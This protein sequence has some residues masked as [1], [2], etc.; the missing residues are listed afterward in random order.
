MLVQVPCFCT[1]HIASLLDPGF[2]V[3]PNNNFKIKVAWKSSP[4]IRWP[5]FRRGGRAASTSSTGSSQSS[6]VAT[7]FSPFIKI[8]ILISS[9]I[10]APHLPTPYIMELL[11][12][13][14]KKTEKNVFLNIKI[15][16]CSSLKHNNLL[17]I[18]VTDWDCQLAFLLS[19]QLF[20]DRAVVLDLLQVIHLLQK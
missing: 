3:H 17:W 4:R 18:M 16:F 9:L 1:Q 2:Q 20:Q 8:L 13:R 5:N 6:Q 7:P 11:K 19:L 12:R 10:H 15:S 14:R